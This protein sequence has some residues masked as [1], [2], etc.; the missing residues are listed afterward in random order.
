MPAPTPATSANRDAWNAYA[1]RYQEEA[2]EHLDGDLWWGPMIPPESRLRV[3]GDV[4][5]RD[6]LEVGSG[7]GQAGLH[8]AK[9]GARVTC[10][11]LSAEQL[12]HG[13]RLAR[14]RGLD[15]RFVE[16][17]GDDLSPFADGSFDVVFSSYAYGFVER[18]DR[19]FAEARRVLRPGGVIAF[20]WSSPLQMS[21]TLGKDGDVE[22]DR[23]YHDRS[24]HVHEDEHGTITSFHRTYGD[25]HAALVGAGLVVTHLLEPAA[26]ETRNHW[27]EAFPPAKLRVVPG[28][29][30]WRA[31]KPRQLAL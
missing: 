12:A 16:G 18:V 13:R 9:L 19:A 24:P 20:S 25:W 8:L 4:A 29:A 11:D 28:T 5:G 23:S 1:S 31:V 15:A 14:E 10:L 21:T 3:L 22:F 17:S 27:P 7:A 30:I 6:V 26:T 2:H